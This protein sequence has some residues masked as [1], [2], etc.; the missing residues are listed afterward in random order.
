MTAVVYVAKRSVIGGHASGGEY[1]L[2]LR[3][4]EGGLALGRKVGAVTQ[5][6]LSDRT[7]T[8]YYYGKTKYDITVIVDGSSERAALEEFLHSTEGLEAFTFSPY[9]TAANLGTTFVARRVDGDYQFERI[10]NSG[11][12]PVEDMM[13][14]SFGI[15]AV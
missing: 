7:E 1:T 5:R 10:D 2:E 13:R 8:L 11:A 9:G 4:A 6:S 12:T 3:I 14:V 15:E